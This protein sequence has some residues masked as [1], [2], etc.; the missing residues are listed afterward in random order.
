[1]STDIRPPQ[2]WSANT[3]RSDGSESGLTSGNLNNFIL[4]LADDLSKLTP[5]TVVDIRCYAST[6]DMIVGEGK[7][8]EERGK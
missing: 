8:R 1:M 5:G 7:V 2:F 4:A 6:E 3:F